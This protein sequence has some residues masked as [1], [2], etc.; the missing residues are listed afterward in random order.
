MS[1]SKLHVLPKNNNIIDTYKLVSIN[2]KYIIILFFFV[3][4]FFFA[5]FLNNSINTLKNSTDLQKVVLIGVSDS[6]I[7]HYHLAKFLHQRGNKGMSKVVSN[8]AIELLYINYQNPKSIKK[9]QEL[10]ISILSIGNSKD[11]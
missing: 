7:F 4:I 11:D 9:L 2:F 1:L 6:P 10:E 3:L 8:V 5:N